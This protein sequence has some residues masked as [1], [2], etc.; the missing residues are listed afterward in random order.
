MYYR[1]ILHRQV[2]SHSN[3]VN[4]KSCRGN[5]MSRYQYTKYISR[6]KLE[7]KDKKECLSRVQRSLYETVY[8]SMEEWR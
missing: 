2:K 4:N 8:L 7:G 1:D 6:R 5:F 3:V